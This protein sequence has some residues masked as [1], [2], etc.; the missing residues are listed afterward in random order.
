MEPYKTLQDAGK[1]ESKYAGVYVSGTGT[2]IWYAKKERQA[3]T[4]RMLFRGFFTDDDPDLKELP[5]R[6]S[7]SKDYVLVGE[8]GEKEL[9]VVFIAMQGEM[10]SPNGEARE[11]I[12]ALGLG[13]TSLSVGDVIE[14][15]GVMWLV[16]PVGFKRLEG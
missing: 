16:A 11:M 5:T 7:L 9:E 15:D 4:A 3:V 13:H 12:E 2:K 1:L 10:W 8:I 6:E 14:V